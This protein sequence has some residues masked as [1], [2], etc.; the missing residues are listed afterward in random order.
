MY[1]INDNRYITSFK[2]DFSDSLGPTDPCST[3]VHMEPFSTLVLKGLTWVFATTTKIC[4]S[5][6]VQADSRP[7][8]STLSLQPSYSW[9]YLIAIVITITAEYEFKATASSIFRAS[10]FGRW[11]V[12]H[13]LENSDF[14]GHLPAVYSNQHLSW[15][16]MSFRASDTLTRRLVHPTAPVLLTKNGPLDCHT[17]TREHG[18]NQASRAS[19]PFKVWE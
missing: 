2:T 4:N 10:C 12:T 3:A 17:S 13:S 5:D 16:L 15:D 1:Y 9:L 6:Q 14:H 11:V 19:H 18:F 8:P 7:T